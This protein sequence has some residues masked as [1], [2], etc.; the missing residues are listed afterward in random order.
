MTRSGGAGSAAAEFL[1]AEGLSQPRLHIGLPDIYIGH[2][3][4]EDCLRDAALDTASIVR[5]I[6]RWWQDLPAQLKT[7]RSA[8]RMAAVGRTPG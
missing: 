1:D 5:R 7:A 8:P 3:S 6:D 4:R 2:G